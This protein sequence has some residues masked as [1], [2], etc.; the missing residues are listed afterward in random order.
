MWALFF[1]A[2]TTVTIDIKPQQGTLDV[3]ALEEPVNALSTAAQ[4]CYQDALKKDAALA[5]EVVLTLRIHLDGHP[6]AKLATDTLK[7]PDASAC[8]LAAAMKQTWPKA[9]IAPVDVDIPFTFQVSKPA[10]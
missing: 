10:K 4:A 7:Q 2:P 1:R 8:M 9:E 3:T 5:G 6:E